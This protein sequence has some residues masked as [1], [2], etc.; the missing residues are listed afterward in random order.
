MGCTASKGSSEVT[1]KMVEAQDKTFI[2][3]DQLKALM[4][5]GSVC[6][7]DCSIVMGEG[8]DPVLTYFK[9]HIEGARY[10]DLKLARDI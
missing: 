6:I 8:E 3:T 4:A 10:L 9:E 7:L 5:A 2:S 1:K